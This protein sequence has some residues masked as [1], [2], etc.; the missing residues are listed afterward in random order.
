[1]TTSKKHE[2]GWSQGGAVPYVT[3]Y[4]AYIRREPPFVKS[5]TPAQK[6][7]MKEKE[8]ARS[9]GYVLDC[10]WPYN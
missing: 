8:E 4:H 1:M 6:G 5:H 9:E 7:R 2:R 10:E 3:G